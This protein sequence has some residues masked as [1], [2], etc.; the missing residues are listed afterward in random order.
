MS[1]DL[2]AVVL[3]EQKLLVVYNGDGSQRAAY[4]LDVPAADLAQDPAGGV[5]ATTQTTQN[6]YWFSG[7]KVMA[8]SRDDLS[9]RWTLSSASGPGIS[10]AQQLVVPIK[11]GL[12]VLNENDGSTIR[13]VGV[14]RRGYAGVV[15]LGAAGPVL[16]EERGT[17]LT[18]LK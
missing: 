15:R 12:A 3:P 10:F 13:T 17:T 16:L 14:D 7:S 2:T 11:G 9:P 8:L 6:M 1:G 18:A 4:P 5:E